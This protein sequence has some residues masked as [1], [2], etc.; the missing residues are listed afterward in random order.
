MS[1]GG[2]T[3]PTRRRSASSRRSSAFRRFLEMSLV[4]TTH[5]I[6]TTTRS[7]HA[8]VRTGS[9][10]SSPK[11]RALAANEAS[12]SVIDSYRTVRQN[13]DHG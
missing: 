10:A 13:R 7:T 4:T 11:G 1:R 9:R 6:E 2:R 5:P 8:T 3:S 12:S